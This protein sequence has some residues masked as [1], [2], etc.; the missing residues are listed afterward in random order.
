[1]CSSTSLWSL[2][3]HLELWSGAGRW[4]GVKGASAMPPGTWPVPVTL[5]AV[6][7]SCFRQQQPW[8]A[9]ILL[10]LCILAGLHGL[11]GWFPQTGTFSFL[12]PFIKE[13]IWFRVKLVSEPQDPF[14][15]AAPGASEGPAQVC[16][17]RNVP[18][19]D[20]EGS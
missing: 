2:R 1:M 4:Q 12:L 15:W 10:V 18:A 7:E 16:I 9:A 20:I 19:G 13:L 6:D 14:P 11:H 17:K 8:P 5:W 3:L